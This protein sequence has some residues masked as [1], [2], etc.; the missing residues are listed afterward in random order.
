MSYEN[1]DT[2]YAVS[3]LFHV[4]TLSL[5]PVSCVKFLV[6]LLLAKISFSFVKIWLSVIECYLVFDFF[7]FFILVN[8]AS[9]FFST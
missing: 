6:M 1:T 4:G 5:S 2:L 8:K 9:T 3:G 7:L